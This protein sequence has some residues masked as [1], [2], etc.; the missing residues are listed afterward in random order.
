MG[1][2]KLRDNKLKEFFA[3]KKQ[4]T[5]HLQA[6]TI[7]HTYNSRNSDVSVRS[8]ISLSLRQSGMNISAHRNGSELISSAIFLVCLL[9]VKIIELLS[10]KSHQFNMIV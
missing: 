5:F 1:I 10:F 4:K 2:E 9:L 3:E 6:V 8:D 7:K